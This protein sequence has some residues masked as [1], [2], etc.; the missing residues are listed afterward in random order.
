MAIAKTCFQWIPKDKFS[1]EYN[2][3]K[4]EVRKNSNGIVCVN[5][6]FCAIK[7]HIQNSK[8]GFC[9]DAKKPLYPKFC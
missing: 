6:K 1:R 5:Y 3:F 2:S 7:Y 8:K 9:T 4:Q